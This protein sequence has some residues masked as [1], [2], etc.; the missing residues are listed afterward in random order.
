MVSTTHHPLY[1]AALYDKAQVV[2]FLL[3]KM[4]APAAGVTSSVQTISLAY[5]LL[6]FCINAEDRPAWYDDFFK[7]NQV[8]LRQI[9]PSASHWISLKH[10]KLKFP[11]ILRIKTIENMPLSLTPYTE[12]DTLT[13]LFFSECD[14]AMAKNLSE[15]I[16]LTQAILD[17]FFCYQQWYR[18]LKYPAFRAIYI[19]SFNHYISHKCTT[20][21]D[22]EIV[23]FLKAL[24]P[25]MDELVIFAQ[26]ANFQTNRPSLY[27]AINLASKIA[28]KESIHHE[29]SKI[30]NYE[31][32]HYLCNLNCRGYLPTDWPQ[33]FYNAAETLK[34]SSHAI[35]DMRKLFTYHSDTKGW[36]DVIMHVVF[37]LYSTN[38]ASF[39]Q[40]DPAV[41]QTPLF[42]VLERLEIKNKK[43]LEQLVVIGL[44]FAS[45]KPAFAQAIKLFLTHSDNAM[46]IIFHKK[47]IKGCVEYLQSTLR[48]LEN[49]NSVPS[50]KRKRNERNAFLPATQDNTEAMNIDDNTENDD[51][52]LTKKR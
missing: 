32:Y 33:Y 43:Q 13:D 2:R 9:Y 38:P 45:L 15:K 5:I 47:S 24:T 36:D 8:Y 28:A 35:I 18:L 50:Q 11:Q 42:I 30:E 48:E 26:Q 49:K 52:R 25:A 7:N 4:P 3:K 22:W 19:E 16:P 46:E 10:S 51:E 20:S 40:K 21:R 17:K 1:V 31:I 6:K 12:T 41:F 27:A 37:F 44:K 34:N 14:D 23:N 29:L 39:Y